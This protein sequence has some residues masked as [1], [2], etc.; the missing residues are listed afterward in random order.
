M[1]CYTIRDDVQPWLYIRTPGADFDCWNLELGGKEPGRDPVF[2]PV[3]KRL[4]LYL[5]EC[6]DAL[7][8]LADG[9]PGNQSVFTGKY[10]LASEVA[11]NNLEAILERGMRTEGLSFFEEGDASALHHVGPTHPRRGGAAL[12]HLAIPGPHIL[13]GTEFDSELEGGR[14]TRKYHA[15]KDAVGITIHRSAVGP[16]GIPE[17]LFCMQKGAGF[18][19]GRLDKNAPWQEASVIWT[20]WELRFLPH[21]RNRAKTLPLA[22]PA[23]V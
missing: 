1:N 5:T 6:F 9:A 14:V 12:V 3:E 7:Q 19:I 2:I 15:F 11:K 16:G 10:E 18:R 8:A 13:Q 22:Q 20:G 17:Y 23:Q 21:R 4:R